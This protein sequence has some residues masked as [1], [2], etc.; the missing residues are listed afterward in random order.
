MSTLSIVDCEKSMSRAVSTQNPLKR[1]RALRLDPARRKALLIQ[2]GVQVFARRGIGASRPTDVAKEAGVAEATIYTYFAS[3]EALV[4]E[5]LDEVARY[6]EELIRSALGVANGS[7]AERLTELVERV[8]DSIDRDPNYAR[9]WFNWSSATRADIWPRFLD[10]ETRII[11]GV[12]ETI[13]DAP[14]GEFAAVGIHP[15]DIA[16][17]LLG[18]AEMI[19]RIKFADRPPAEVRRFIQS[20]LVLILRT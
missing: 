11:S 14:N 7:V 5:V 4:A 15:Q 2:A 8:A 1:P 16:R 17:L 18:C 3:R 20:A 19:A 9:V 6:Y 13:R 12:T 10:A